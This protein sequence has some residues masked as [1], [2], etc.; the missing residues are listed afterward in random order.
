M[1]KNTKQIADKLGAAHLGQIHHSPAGAFGMTA[2]AHLL[3]QRL[4]PSHGIRMGRPTDP[5]WVLREAVPMS[6]QTKNCLK[7]MADELST[8]HRKISPMQ[9]AAQLLEQSVS[10]AS[11][12]N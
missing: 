4:Q 7:Q 3:G 9:L 5:S 2:R 1:A 12:T 10:A 8:E 11:F 6:E